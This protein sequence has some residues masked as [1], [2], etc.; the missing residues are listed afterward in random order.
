MSSLKWRHWKADE[1]LSAWIVGIMQD[2]IIPTL[3]LDSQATATPIKS[4]VK[5]LGRDSALP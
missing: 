5:P 2:P 4:L 3:T 1:R